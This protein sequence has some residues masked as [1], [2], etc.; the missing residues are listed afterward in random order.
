MATKKSVLD[1]SVNSFLDALNHPLRKEIDHLRQI[2][3]SV[4]PELTETIK[5]NGPNY[6]YQNDDRITI[7]IQ[8]PKLIH[9]IF[10]TGAKKQALPKTK[11]ISVE[12][13][14]LEWKDNARAVMAFKTLQDIKASETELRA[15]VEAWL[16]A[17]S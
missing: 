10:H 2:I 13:T 14:R 17:A 7:K 9:L 1:K 4:N 6:V 12:S 11:L 16:A 3:L 15:I 5:W 8:P